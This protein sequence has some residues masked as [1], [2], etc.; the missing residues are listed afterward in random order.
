MLH[1]SNSSRPIRS[2]QIIRVGERGSKQRI[3]RKLSAESRDS[4]LSILG[5]C[6]GNMAHEN[7]K[8]VTSIKTNGSPTLSNPAGRSPPLKDK[9]LF[10]L[11]KIDQMPTGTVHNT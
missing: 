9:L 7:E 4:A 10:L 5:T 3:Q 1:I 8:T 2:S 11:S 6:Q